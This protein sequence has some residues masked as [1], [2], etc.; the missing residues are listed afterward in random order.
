[1]CDRRATWGPACAEG[2]DC[3]ETSDLPA[4]SF[5]SLTRLAAF[6]LSQAQANPLGS[7]L[8]GTGYP[9]GKSNVTSSA[10]KRG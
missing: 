4:F 8:R 10:K 6:L 3:K 5:Q 2:G 9:S 7:A 1:M